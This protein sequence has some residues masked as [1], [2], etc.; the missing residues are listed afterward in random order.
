MLCEVCASCHFDRV[1][2]CYTTS[3]SRILTKCCDTRR[4]VAEY[5]TLILS[6]CVVALYSRYFSHVVATAMLETVY[7]CNVARCFPHT[8]RIQTAK[9]GLT[10]AC[11]S[12]MSL[13]KLFL[14]IHLREE[15]RTQSRFKPPTF[16]NGGA[17]VAAKADC[18]SA[19]SLHDHD[20][21][22]SRNIHLGFRPPSSLSGHHVHT[23][24]RSSSPP[25]A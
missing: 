25:P 23:P 19:A 10:C 6:I 3:W 1:P 17:N 5:F 2:A 11:E 16:P 13:S 9:R 4:S 7:I 21:A 14:T 15:L 24:R 20:G 8:D 18:P 12:P 22:Q